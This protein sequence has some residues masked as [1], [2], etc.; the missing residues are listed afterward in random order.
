MSNLIITGLLVIGAMAAWRAFRDRGT[1][2]RS[3]EEEAARRAT[4]H[5]THK[6]D[7][8]TLE[9]G[10]DGVYRPKDNSGS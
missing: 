6:T 2:R 5:M 7:R 4:E 1:D 9:P 3:A 10:R 8:Q